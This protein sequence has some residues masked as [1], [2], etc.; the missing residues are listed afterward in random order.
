MDSTVTTIP[1]AHWSGWHRA[2]RR[3]RWR[4]ICT[5]EDEQTCRERLHR[6]R[7]GGDFLTRRPGQGDPNLDRKPR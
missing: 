1:A 7:S 2:N 6:L 4:L 5:N 3:A